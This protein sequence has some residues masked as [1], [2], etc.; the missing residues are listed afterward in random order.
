MEIN[1]SFWIYFA[2]F[3]DGEGHIGLY[4]KKDKNVKCG[5]TW[6]F[7]SS[8]MGTDEQ[9]IKSL[10]EDL[11]RGFMMKRVYKN[12]KHTPLFKVGFTKKD[13]AFILPKILPYLRSKKRMVELIL[14]A[15]PRRADRERIY[16][17]LREIRNPR[18]SRGRP[19]NAET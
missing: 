9:L 8:I 19:K 4:K 3:F 15:L 10:Y 13:L 14:E 16:N 5:Y 12:K 18:S 11:G 17:E 2:G 1:N 6:T 7:N